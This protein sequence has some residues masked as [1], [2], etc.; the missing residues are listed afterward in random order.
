MKVETP[1]L[2]A[3]IPT[4]TPGD[5]PSRGVFD[6]S[7]SARLRADCSVLATAAVGCLGESAPLSETPAPLSETPAGLQ[8]RVQSSG[9]DAQRGCVGPTNVGPLQGI[10]QAL[11][12]ARRQNENVCFFSCVGT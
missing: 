3:L 6:P 5:A 7:W 8:K 11:F 12:T 9:V 4:V 1:G 10:P 2:N